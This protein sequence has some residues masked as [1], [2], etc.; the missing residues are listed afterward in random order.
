[1]SANVY[2]TARN[3][4]RMNASNIPDRKVVLKLNEHDASRLLALI[5]REMSEEDKIWHP[6]W[7]RLAQNVEQSIEQASANPLRPPTRSRDV[8]GD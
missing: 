3:E 6:Y 4:T 7:E 2:P 8:L 1:M 5:R